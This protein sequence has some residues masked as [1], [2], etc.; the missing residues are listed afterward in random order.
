MGKL[1]LSQHKYTLSTYDLISFGRE[2][3]KFFVWALHGIF[4]DFIY[5]HDINWKDMKEE[6]VSP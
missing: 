3:K 6:F 5:F 1:N 2:K 4:G